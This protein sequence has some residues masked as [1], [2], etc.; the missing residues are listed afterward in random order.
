[1]KTL[2]PDF[3]ATHNGKRVDAS[4]HS[5]LLRTR[6]GSNAAD[7][8]AIEQAVAAGLLSRE[9]ATALFRGADAAGDYLDTYARA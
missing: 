7:D 5:A 8:A 2:Q 3:A 4:L 1:M 9:E 6:K